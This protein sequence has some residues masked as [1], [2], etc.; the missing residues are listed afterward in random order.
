[1]FV[2]KWKLDS[3]SFILIS[4]TPK[5]N[6]IPKQPQTTYQHV[7]IYGVLVQNPHR[8]ELFNIRNL[9]KLKDTSKKI[10]K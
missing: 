9:K 5:L 1:M 2:L 6:I 4:D 10:D 3:Y 7:L 8:L